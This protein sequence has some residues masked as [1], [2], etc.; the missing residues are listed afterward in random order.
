MVVAA[1]GDFTYTVEAFVPPT[2]ATVA[3]ASV[4]KFVT[5]DHVIGEAT[6][7]LQSNIVFNLFKLKVPAGLL[8]T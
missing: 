5:G 6:A 3:A 4:Y 7:L 1:V 2:Y 8:A